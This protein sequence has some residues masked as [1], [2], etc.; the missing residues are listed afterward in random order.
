MKWKQLD[1]DEAHGTVWLRQEGPYTLQVYGDENTWGFVIARNRIIVQCVAI[2][3]ETE[4]KAKELAE[5]AFAQL[6]RTWQRPD[7]SV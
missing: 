2:A 3:A 7:A 5:A 6:P 4:R 1:P